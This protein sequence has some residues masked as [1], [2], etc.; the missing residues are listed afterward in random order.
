MRRFVAAFAMLVGATLVVFT[1]S[2]HLASRS[3]DAQTI[4]DHYR[5]LMSA[6]GL[7]GLHN[8]FD[9]LKAAGAQ[10]DDAALPRLREVMGMPQA[11]F[12]ALVATQMPHIKAFNDQAPTVVGLVGPVIDKMEA[13]RADYALAS[14]IPTSFLGLSSAPWLFLGIGGLLLV[15]G[16]FGLI[17]PQRLVSVALVVVGLGI[18]VAPLVIGIP[19]K[20]DAAVR[21]T[22][23][24]AIGLAP[25]TGQKALAATALFDGMASDVTNKLEPMLANQIHVDPADGQRTFAAEFPT[26]ATFSTSW[27]STIS[28]QSHA[29]SS[30]QVALASTFANANKI[31]L[32]PIPWLFIGPGIALALLGAASLVPVRRRVHAPAP[33]L[34]IEA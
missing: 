32:R 8:G 20:I 14:Q 24:G 13:E 15:I 33:V 5:S 6:Q 11:Q 7:A 34:S 4:A 10:L 27:E 21:V 2:E 29:L 26:L 17:R 18:V 25:A 22:Q 9:T 23:V 30:S 31:P 16:A 28:A 3:R 12:D 19:G 1:F